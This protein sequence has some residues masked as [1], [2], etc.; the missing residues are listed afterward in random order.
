M[1]RYFFQAALLPDGWQ[2]DVRLG[3]DDRGRIES[4]TTGAQPGADDLCQ[5]VA[6]PMLC[7][8]HSHVFQRAM[9]GRAEYRHAVEDDFWSWRDLMY[10]LAAGLDAD[11]LHA[12]AV[13]AY[14]RMRAMGYERVCEFHYLH[15]DLGQMD[16]A[17]RM[18]RVIVHA[19]R[20][21]GIGLTLLPVL[22]SH[23]GFGAQAPSAAQQRFILDTGEYLDL[24]DH[25]QGELLAGQNLGLC[26]HSLR[27]VSPEQM[28]AV[29]ARSDAAWPV[30]IHIAE[31]LPE[32]EQ[33][34]AHHGQRPVQ[35]LMDHF[36][37]SPRW[38]LVHA[39]HLDAAEKQA[40]NASG[41]VACLCP[42]TEANLGDGVFDVP[43]LINGGGTLAIGSDS[44]V[45]LNP[46][47]ELKML[48][49]SQRLTLRRRNVCCDEAQPQVAAYLWQ[50][51]MRGGAAAAGVATGGLR[52]G[53]AADW[54][55]L[56][57]DAAW[58]TAASPEDLLSA[59]VFS[60][61]VNARAWCA[62]R[63]LSTVD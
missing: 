49:Y 40:L 9:A 25:L 3:V 62:G 45:E 27:A 7:N 31:Q 59:W 54:L 16:D 38:T 46:A 1:N 5:P 14:R 32:V 61:R 2:R 51:A 56:H 33:C 35:W 4:L 57:G 37:V 44:Q 55:A 43:A 48:E 39:T 10:R 36:D 13:D 24:L 11:A 41:A 12:V 20:D 47:A 53:A 21:A 22:Y 15:R 42:L 34:L 17:L 28:H 60:D 19:A 6:V 23:S 29:L 8:A 58:P 18:S 63:A 50:A 26:F 30:H 52:I